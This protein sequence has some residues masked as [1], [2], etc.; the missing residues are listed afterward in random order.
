MIV[1]S[2]HFM[3]LIIANHHSL[4]S[5]RWF[6]IQ[7]PHDRGT[8]ARGSHEPRDHPLLCPD[9]RG[10]GIH[11]DARYTHTLTLTLSY[12]AIHVTHYCALMHEATGSMM[13]LGT[14]THPRP[15][16]YCNAP[17]FIMQPTLLYCGWLQHTHC[18]T[19]TRPLLHKN[20][21]SH[22]LLYCYTVSPILQRTLSYIATYV[23][24]YCNTPA[25][26]YIPIW[27]CLI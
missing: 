19:A 8:G 18:Y 14:Y 25:P 20:T 7:Q 12:I 3:S 21:P 1:P 2:H 6:A 26:S 4:L 11:D 15:L 13:M 16:L 10:H 22:S 23:V 24:P 27:Y 17:F 5:P 9:A